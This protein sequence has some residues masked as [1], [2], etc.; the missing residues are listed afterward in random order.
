MGITFLGN[1]SA[2]VIKDL[3]KETC[4]W[5][6]YVDGSP[7]NHKLLYKRKARGRPCD[8]RGRDWSNV[9]TS[10]VVPATPEAGRSRKWTFPKH[11]AGYAGEDRGPANRFQ[12]SETD[13]NFW[14]PEL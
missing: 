9:A 3:A 12:P 4:S 13:L 14:S 2:G 11:W 1:I 7:T 8:H 6:V 5:I 10:Q